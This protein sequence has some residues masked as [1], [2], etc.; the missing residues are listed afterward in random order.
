MWSTLVS[1]LVKH[2]RPITVVIVF[3]SAIGYHYWVVTDY[4]EELKHSENVVAIVTNEY[5]RALLL[6]EHNAEELDKFKK[7]QAVVMNVLKEKHMADLK[8]LQDIQ[9]ILEGTRNV[10]DEDDGNVSNVIRSTLDGLRVLR[11]GS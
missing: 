8:R 11:Q 5:E 4:E 9:K 3:L 10:K 6:V 1:F 7:R 2:F